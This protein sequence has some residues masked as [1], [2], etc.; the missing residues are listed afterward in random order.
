[1]QIVRRAVLEAAWLTGA[2]RVEEK[3]AHKTTCANLLI[4]LSL[5][6]RLLRISHE[7][8]DTRTKSTL[9]EVRTV[10]P[11]CFSNYSKAVVVT[12]GPIVVIKKPAI[13]FLL[14]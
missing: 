4:E 8:W 6:I 5:K 14:L 2:I 7:R 12:K 13:I 3:R 10:K 9:C 1:M 11:L